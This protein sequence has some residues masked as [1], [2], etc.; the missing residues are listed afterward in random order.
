MKSLFKN[1]AAKDEYD[2]QYDQTLV[3]FG[4][5]GESRRIHT[6]FGETHV[7]I[8]GDRD[9]PPLVLLHGMTMSSTM[10]YP[11]MKAL[12]GQR[13]VYAIDSVGDFGKSKSEHHIKTREEANKWLYEVLYA[14]EIE[15]TDMAGH[16][17]GGFMAM[18][19]ALAYPERISKLLLYA[20]AGAFTRVSLRFIMKIYPALLFHTDQSI[21]KAF[22]WFSGNN[23]PLHPVFRNQIL[24]GYKTAK[25]LQRLMPS[26]I[27]EDEFANFHVPTLLLVG[28]REVIYSPNKA[29]LAAKSRISHLKSYLI[30]EA[31][32]ALTIEQADRV[33]ELSLQF[34]GET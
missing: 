32:H 28:G 34:L 15:K 30:P 20:P 4:M 31:S 6:S 21:D 8:Y 25:P 5:A 3:L 27:S 26:V 17:M 14:L 12:C 29:I 33:N 16:S 19:F 1:E 23:Q 2:R 10:W 11:N 9:K 18:N 24:A 22:L 7:L 13:C